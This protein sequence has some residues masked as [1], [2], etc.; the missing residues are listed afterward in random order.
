MSKP[1]I[2]LSSPS[3]MWFS[4]IIDNVE[5]IILRRPMHKVLKSFV[6]L[7]I[8]SDE[9]PVSS[10][11]MHDPGAASCVAE[12]L[13]P[14]ADMDQYERCIAYLLDIEARAQ[15]F[16]LN[17]PQIKTHNITLESIL[18]TEGREALVSGAGCSMERC[19]RNVV[20]QRG[21]QS[22]RI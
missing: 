8:F 7:G 2:C 15:A 5:V 20:C 10:K 14:V 19:F 12:P 17:F 22:P 18:E 21:Q 11:W 1:V 13:K 9:N 16:S 6:E 4:T 3:M